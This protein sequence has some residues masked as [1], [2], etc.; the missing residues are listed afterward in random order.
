MNRSIII[1]TKIPAAGN[2]KTRLQPFLASEECAALAEA[3]FQDAYK[4]AKSVCEN[5]ILAYSPPV[6]PDVL[7]NFL[8]PQSVYVEQTGNDLGARMSNAF[9][10][11]FEK[12]FDS[13][14]MIG[15][16][17]PTFPSD[18]IEKAFEFLETN[19]DVVLGRTEDGGFYLIGLKKLQKEIFENVAWSSPKTFGQVYKNIEK[20][21]LH[22]REVPG[23]YDV[24]EPEDYKKL[25]E[26]I[27]HNKNAQ[28][29]APETYALIRKWEKF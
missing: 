7:K 29:R 25:R 23:W 21:N 1:M 22:L 10:F 17:I 27:L 4:K 6:E 13:V 8:P 19:S 12:K 9:K 14:V 5:V 24:D 26:E 2:V 20:L 28:R 16:D 11:A 15:T 18:F 3:F